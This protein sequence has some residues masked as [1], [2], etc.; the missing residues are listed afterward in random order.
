MSAL[1]QNPVELTPEQPLLQRSCSAIS[2]HVKNP[3]AGIAGA[4]R[5]LAARLP[6]PEAEAAVVSE[7]LNR[8]DDL[9]DSLDDLSIFSR[10]QRPKKFLISATHLAE[11]AVSDLVRKGFTP[12]RFELPPRD[13]RLHGDPTLLRRAVVSLLRNAAEAVPR[14]GGD[15]VVSLCEAEAHA[16]FHVRDN[17]SGMAPMA[18][19]R[20]FEPFFTTKSRHLGLGLPIAQRIVTAHGGGLICTRSDEEGT[21][22]TIRLPVHAPT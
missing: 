2:H 11:E 10:E 18:R 13:V 1:S 17:G 20:M 22:M 15:I 4:L 12:V 8:I 9:N 21:E 5:I 6:L 16:Q 3:L 14:E 7:I 19:D